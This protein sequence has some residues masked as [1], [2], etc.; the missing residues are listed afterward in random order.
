MVANQWTQQDQVILAPD[1][2]SCNIGGLNWNG[3]PGQNFP[4]FI[5]SGYP[6]D[7]GPAMLSEHIQTDNMNMPNMMEAQCF[8]P[9]DGPGSYFTGP[10][11]SIRITGAFNGQMMSMGNQPQICGFLDGR[12]NPKPGQVPIY[13]DISRGPGG[14]WEL[15]D[16]LNTGFIFASCIDYPGPVVQLDAGNE[17]DLA[18]PMKPVWI[19]DSHVSGG[20]VEST[21]L[22]I[23]VS[24][25]TRPAPNEVYQNARSGDFTYA[26]G[27]YTPGSSHYVRLHFAEV[28]QNAP[29]GS[30]QFNVIINGVQVLTRADIVQMAG[31]ALKATVQQFLADADQT[32]HYNIVFQSVVSNALV[33]G[34]EMQ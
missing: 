17:A 20:Q 3:R 5:V 1:Y 19:A 9:N 34:I 31:G 25:A 8:C 29:V 23:D 2:C 7:P 28:I 14:D 18:K 27:G 33:S 4:E 13:W 32:G 10:G 30:R 21:S 16:L 22:G 24:Q 26:F 6:T 15:V 12:I 11:G